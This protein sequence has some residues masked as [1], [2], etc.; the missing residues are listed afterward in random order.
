MKTAFSMSDMEAIE[1]TPAAT[2][3]RPMVTFEELTFSDG[4]TVA[5][6]KA[7][8][9][10]FVGP[11]NAGKSAALRELHTHIG[12]NIQQTIIKNA[13][14][15]RSGTLD[16]LQ[17]FLGDRD[18]IKQASRSNYTGFRYSIPSTHLGPFWQS[19]L[20]PLRSIFCSWI[21][22]TSR[23]T[24]SDPVQSISIL[25]QQPNHPIHLLYANDQLEFRIS[26]Y[27]R[28]AFG[29]D[30]IVFHGGGATWPLL[31][32]QRPTPNV[33]EDRVSASYIKRLRDRTVPLA[34]QGDGMRS[35]ASVILELL[36]PNTPSVLLLDEP[37]AFLHPPQ[38]RLLG[39]FIA[40]ERPNQAQ[41]FVATH[42]A[43]LLQGLLNTGAQHLR[44]LRIQR[45]GSVNRVKELDKKRAKEIAAD[46]IMKFTP[47]LSG[48][49]HQR[50]IIAESDA[51]CMF[52][53]S[54]LDLPSI[55]GEQRPD[56][57]FIQ[58]N[59]KHRLAAIAEALRA[60]DVMVD[61]IADMDVLNDASV[62]QR[63]V[64]A[65]DGS[66][67]A[68]HVHA[69]PLKHAIE[70]HKPWLNAAEITKGIRTILD[71]APPSGEFPRPSRGQ[72]EALFRKASPWDIIKDA[73]ET[74]IPPGQPRQHYDALYEICASIGLWIVPVGQLEGFCKSIGGHGPRWVQAVLEER[75]LATS[76]ELQTARDFMR[77][78]WNRKQ[79]PPIKRTS[80]APSPS[81]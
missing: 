80:A 60:L 72:I 37:E 54:I 51:D 38:A 22:T 59:G 46:P 41:L 65:L 55:H 58:A 47:V 11:N 3:T 13:K 42:S 67:D 30:L 45:V 77:R 53:S 57:L 34:S 32:G 75:D 1:E 8:I 21:A 20:E 70:Q 64:M 69:D 49:F 48:I 27:F 79:L 50:V 66:W 63:I 5:L 6:D 4:S 52:Y 7:D 2:T 40:K 43:E 18:G 44:V 26:S 15:R 31:V 29:E 19:N 14:L 17:T 74:A 25:D 24:A 10:V 73:G 78:I 12:R 56:V 81:P 36:A 61:V 23:I 33:D 39:E 35:F 68:V 71:E 16:D 28:R 76:A 9:I 62:L